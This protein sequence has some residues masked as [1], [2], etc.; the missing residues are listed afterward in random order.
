MSCKKIFLSLGAIFSVGNSLFRFSL[1]LSCL[2]FKKSNRSELLLFKSERSS[3]LKKKTRAKWADH[4][5]H[6][7]KRKG[8]LLFMTEGFD[9][10]RRGYS[11]KEGKL[12]TGL[13]N[14]YYTFWLCFLLKTKES[15]LLFIAILN[16]IKNHS[17]PGAKRAIHSFKK[18]IR[19]ICSFWS[20]NDRFAWKTK[21]GIPNPGRFL[22]RKE[23]CKT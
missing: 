20:K 6:L 9:L 17:I 7:I 3:L 22:M 2:S 11:F 13:T 8:D 21:K 15:E 16:Q 4:S 18:S 1:F 12:K 10:F 5:F 23:E 19:G 14:L